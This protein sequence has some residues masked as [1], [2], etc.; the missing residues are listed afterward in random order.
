MARIDQQYHQL[1][2]HIIETGYK[3][4]DPNRKGTNRIE[5]E[6]YKLHI[7][8]T[9]GFPALTTKKL[10]WKSVVGE[11]LWFLKGSSDIRELWKDN[12]HIWDKD[13]LNYH[14][15]YDNQELLL[16]GKDSDHMYGLGPIYGNQWRDWMGESR[17][18]TKESKSS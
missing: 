4:E 18:I 10:A 6:D 2:R 5:I 13:W 9:K 16:S 15:W 11:L 7:D 8:L 17:A 12:I 3:Y 1:L 14:S